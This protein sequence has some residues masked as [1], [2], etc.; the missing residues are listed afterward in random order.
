MRTRRGIGAMVLAAMA[1]FLTTLPCGAAP[2]APDYDDAQLLA[3]LKQLKDT[4]INVRM[5]AAEA[6]SRVRPLPPAIIPPILDAVN[7][8]D[9]GIRK[10][11]LTLLE[12]VGAGQQGAE[13][14]F[15]AAMKDKDAG[16]RWCA[17]HAL[18]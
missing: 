12:W 6:L 16:V 5:K 9:A 8:K 17:A 2:K 15:F 1:Y 18:G 14:A 7:D 4:D 10:R 13:A 3:W 11:A